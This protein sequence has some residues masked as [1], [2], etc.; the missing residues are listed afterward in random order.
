MDA[1]TFAQA[2]QEYL[3]EY[4]ILTDGNLRPWYCPRHSHISFRLRERAE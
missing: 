3:I 4:T 2:A 1:K